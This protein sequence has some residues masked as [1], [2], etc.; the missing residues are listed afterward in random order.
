MVEK[1][2]RIFSFFY[3]PSCQNWQCRK[4]TYWF[5]Y[6]GRTQREKR[7]LM[8]AGGSGGMGFRKQGEVA[9]MTGFWRL[10]NEVFQ[11]DWDVGIYNRGSWACLAFSCYRALPVLSTVCLEHFLPSIFMAHSF[12]SFQA[13][14]QNDTL[15]V[16]Q[17]PSLTEIATH[18]LHSSFLSCFMLS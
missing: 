14:A 18:L 7:N 13:S 10:G 5:K 2:E 6:C 11:G 16:R 3:F 1:L 15:S 12:T 8:W 4:E 9:P 17:K